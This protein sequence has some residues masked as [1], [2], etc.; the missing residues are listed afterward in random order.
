MLFVAAWSVVRVWGAG[1]AV[2]GIDGSCVEPSVGDSLS[3]ATAPG[4][5]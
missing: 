1:E 3:V 5:V 4:A 2:G